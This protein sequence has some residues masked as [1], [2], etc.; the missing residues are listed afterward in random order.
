M[1]N[2]AALPIDFSDLN[3]REL[4]TASSIVT[5]IIWI[6]ALIFVRGVII[7]YVRKD[8]EILAKEQRQWII[9]IKNLSKPCFY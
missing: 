2:L 6:A 4:F 1:N 5:T 7:R 9:R 3:L 8:A